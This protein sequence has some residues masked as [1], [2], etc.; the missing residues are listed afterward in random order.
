MRKEAKLTAG[1]VILAPVARVLY[2]IAQ[3]HPENRGVLLAAGG[4]FVAIL[5]IVVLMD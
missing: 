4:G 3:D 5:I 1:M 2:H